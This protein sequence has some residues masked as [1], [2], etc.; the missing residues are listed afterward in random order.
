VSGDYRA[1]DPDLYVTFVPEVNADY[2]RM[3]VPDSADFFAATSLV[4]HSEAS[5]KA[6]SNVTDFQRLTAD[7]QTADVPAQKLLP[8]STNEL[9]RLGLRLGRATLYQAV[10]LEE[11]GFSR[12][13][14]LDFAT[15]QWSHT[16][17]DPRSWAIV[18]LALENGIRHLALYTAGNA[19]ISLARLVYA[20]NKE[21]DENRRITVY[22]LVD[23]NV[24]AEIQTMLK[25]LG[26]K[27]AVVPGGGAYI[28]NEA[29][30]WRI[31]NEQILKTSSPDR[32][33]HAWHVTDGWDGVGIAMYRLLIAQALRSVDVK[34]VVTPVGTGNLLLGTYLGIC[35]ASDHRKIQLFGALPNGENILTN[36]KR[37]RIPVTQGRK[38]TPPSSLSIMPKLVGRY[39]PLAPC[40]TH[41][42]KEVK[43]VT[44]DRTMQEAARHETFGQIA[45]EPSALAAF[46]SLPAISKTAR[47]IEKPHLKSY[48]P[49]R[50]DSGVLVVNTGSGLMSDVEIKFLSENGQQ[51]R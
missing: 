14:V 21:L 31:V 50:T 51:R 24:A 34:Y 12:V 20:A 40:L 17:K 19:G 8:Y 25:S 49:F 7:I 28:L 5:R 9:E 16:L 43:F 32:P 13:Y 2:R 3:I 27:V 30:V 45:C 35:D 23:T 42:E 38:K 33:P 6:A 26:S 10:N 41:I 39:T 37:R 11:S 36:L 44:I 22:S 4:E 29:N 1:T 18:N 47:K 48:L 15:Y 46:A